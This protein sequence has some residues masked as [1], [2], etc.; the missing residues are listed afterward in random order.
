MA[1]NGKCEACGATGATVYIGDQLLCDRCVAT[2]TGMPPV[3]DAP[4]DETIAG[5]DGR[6]HRFRFRVWRSPT[7]IVVDAQEADVPDGD[8]FHFKL[9]GAHDADVASLVDRLRRRM[10][11]GI[12]RTNLEPHPRGEGW[13]ATG[14]EIVG[15][16]AHS[17]TAKGGRPF[18]VVVDGRRL[19]WEEFGR[20]LDPFEGWDF[21]VRVDDIEFVDLDDGATEAAYDIDIEEA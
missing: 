1:G 12:S 10:R 7:G 20:A 13:I 9:M 6:S 5:P 2:M 21:T 11:A 4:A 16:L 19:S 3:P 17:N 15:R 8:G 18:D 14:D